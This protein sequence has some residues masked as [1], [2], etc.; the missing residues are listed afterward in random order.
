MRS[1]RQWCIAQDNAACCG[2]VAECVCA[3]PHGG[4]RSM[5]AVTNTPRTRARPGH[6][7]KAAAAPMASAR[8][9]VASTAAAVPAA[10]VPREAV[11][12]S[13]RPIRR[14]EPIR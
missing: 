1:T 11:H 2:T 8:R 14:S 6:W 3:V 13:A 4:E 10:A 5:R 9:E 12:A 7:S